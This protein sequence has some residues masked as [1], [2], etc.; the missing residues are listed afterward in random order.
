MPSVVNA[1]AGNMYGRSTPRVSPM[2]SA[3]FRSLHE[4]GMM[5]WHV[6][7][8]TWNTHDAVGLTGR[9]LYPESVR[10]DSRT[11][12]D[13]GGLAFAAKRHSMNELVE[14]REPKQACHP[15]AGADKYHAA[16]GVARGAVHL[17]KNANAARVHLRDE[18]EIQGERLSRGELS[19][20]G[21]A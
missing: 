21:L 3:I 7:K 11:E 19:F 8:H 17:G 20:S 5:R 16:S 1:A 10:L 6:S 15:I 18:R 4:D 14:A 2:R 13:V 12:R 9:S